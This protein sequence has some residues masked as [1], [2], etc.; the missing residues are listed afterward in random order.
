M[1]AFT[2]YILKQGRAFLYVPKLYK[3]ICKTEICNKLLHKQMHTNARCALFVT[4][5]C[6]FYKGKRNIYHFF[7]C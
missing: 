2:L 7:Y 5:G 1:Y 3:H 4:V 6:V